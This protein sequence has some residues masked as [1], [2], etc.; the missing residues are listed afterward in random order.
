MNTIFIQAYCH[1]RDNLN[2]QERTVLDFVYA[3]H[4][5]I[6]TLKE[7]GDRL[8]I[9]DSRVAQIRNKAE[10]SLSSLMMKTIH[11]I[12]HTKPR[13]QSFVSIISDLPDEVLIKLLQATRPW[14]LYSPLE[15]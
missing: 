12:D 10:R 2:Q 8:D 6:L 4:G 13:K 15:D 7:I 11:E 5:E 14:E 9:S 3:I 1:Y